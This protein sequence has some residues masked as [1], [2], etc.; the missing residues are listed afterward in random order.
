[1]ANK[2]YDI[3]VRRIDGTETTLADYQGKALLLVNVASKCGLTKQYEG[4]EN[5]YKENKD[6]G[7]EVLGFPANNFLAQEPGTS[8]E[9]QDFCTTNY[10]VTFPLFEKI[11]VKG[12]DQHP[13]YKYLTDERGEADI[14]NGDA[15]EERLAGLD[16]KR[17]KANDILWNFEKFVIG[18]DGSLAARIAP[19]VTVED[20]RVLEAINSELA[21]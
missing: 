15:F 16:Q 9:I 8:D 13:L 20:S 1:M 7:F 18:K 4:L 14:S 2:I 11:S 5:L 10:G 12:D 3:P 21:K 19:D 17:G 6:K